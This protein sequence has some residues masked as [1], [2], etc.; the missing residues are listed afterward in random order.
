M[1]PLNNQI[2]LEQAKQITEQVIGDPFICPSVFQA[3]KLNNK[4]NVWQI[5]RFDVGEVRWSGWGC[6]FWCVFGARELREGTSYPMVYL[7]SFERCSGPIFWDIYAT[8]ED[9]IA[10]AFA[11]GAE[12]AVRMWFRGGEKRVSLAKESATSLKDASQTVK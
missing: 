4:G 3:K 8:E 5:R 10:A 7:R 12:A 2:T 11:Q 1:N 9:A 6:D